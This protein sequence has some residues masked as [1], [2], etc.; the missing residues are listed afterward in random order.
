MMQLRLEYLLSRKLD[1]PFRHKSPFF[2]TFV[3]PPEKFDAIPENDEIG[4]ISHRFVL[5]KSGVEVFDKYEKEPVKDKEIITFYEEESYA[6]SNFFGTACRIKMGESAKELIRSID[7]L[8]QHVTFQ[9]LTDGYFVSGL[10]QLVKV[11]AREKNIDA[12]ILK[13]AIYLEIADK[14]KLNDVFRKV[15]SSNNKLADW[16][17]AGI[18]AI[19][20]W[21]FTDEN[22]DY[23][24]HF[25]N[26]RGSNLWNSNGEKPYTYKPIIPIPA[27]MTFV[28][29]IH[30]TNQQ[31]I[32]N[33]GLKKL[34][35]FIASFD[36]IS[37]A[38]VFL[39]AQ[40]TPTVADDIFLAAVYY[41]KNFMEEHIPESIKAIYK[42]LKNVFQEVLNNT[43][44]IIG[45]IKEKAGIELARINAFLCVV[46]NGLI[47]LA[48][49]IIMLLAMVTENIPILELEKLSASELAKHQEKLEFIEDFVDLFSENAKIL[50]E[51]IKD[52]FKDGKVWKEL[53]LFASELKKKFLS[54]NEYFWAYFIGGVAF[55]LILDAVLAYF[56][57]GSSLIAQASA[58]IGRITKQAEQMATKGI[59]FGK[60]IE[61][62]VANSVEDLLKW[63]KKEFE[64]LVEAIK[65]GKLGSYLKKK[66]SNLVGEVV[67]E[68][69]E[70]G[71]S[72]LSKFAIEFR[73][74]L[75]APAHNGNI[76]VFEYLDKSGK[77]VKK[78]FS[79]EIDLDAHAEN[80]G[81]QWLKKEGIPK[82]NVK[83]V[84]SELE[85]C[86]LGKHNCK[87]LIKD[88]FTKANME[89]S[90]PYPGNDV[91]RKAI[92]IRRKS[93]K[94]RIKT[95]KQLLK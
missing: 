72:E 89:Y 9:G 70:Y 31:T 19:E 26:I 29:S 63:L 20:K 67:E 41:V 61:K 55:E 94:D 28:D 66:F 82:E 47:S 78:A 56:T 12:D 85:P 54:L 15:F 32:V 49:V 77:L 30:G 60:S 14:N 86:G 7:N 51:G 40:A 18:E 22:Y 35:G 8:N 10:N 44:L 79:T 53:S 58:K 5:C 21:K 52:L 74:T 75:P 90:F 2:E 46:L 64:E 81:L 24:K 37:T 45:F 50:L 4:K 95:L 34:S 88:N 57:G 27:F 93:I 83:T 48:Q 92:D 17:S 16:L 91:D 76:A 80:I 69:V 42:K 36:E 38:A 39:V 25:L 13:G 71:V 23:Q 73:K 65:T 33:S 3:V 68:I 43:K 62:K 11:I 87:K 59:D 6:K 1:N 84:Y